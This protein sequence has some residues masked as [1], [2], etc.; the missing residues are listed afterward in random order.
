MY[1]CVYVCIS[2]FVENYIFLQIS[3]LTCHDGPLGKIT[4]FRC[5]ATGHAWRPAEQRMPGVWWQV[6]SPRNPQWQLSRVDTPGMS[7]VRPQPVPWHSKDCRTASKLTRRSTVLPGWPLF[8]SMTRPFPLTPGACSTPWPEMTIISTKLREL[9]SS[10]SCSCRAVHTVTGKTFPKTEKIGWIQKRTQ[11][12]LDFRFWPEVPSS[13]Q[14]I[15]T[16]L[17]SRFSSYAQW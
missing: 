15:T 3:T 13:T 14:K 4:P 8:L 2:H 10:H 7:G 12:A 11:N 17:K 16:C 5:R 6:L 9:L 1:V